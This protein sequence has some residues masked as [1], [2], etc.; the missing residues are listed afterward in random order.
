MG[1]LDKKV[2]VI[3]GSSRGIGKAIALEFAREGANIV[4]VAR[5]ETEGKLPGTIGKTAQEVEALGVQALAIKGDVTKEDDV[6]NVVSNTLD[7]FGRIDILV[8]NAAVGYYLPLMDTPAKH[9][10]LVMEINVKGPFLL[11]KAIV[12]WMTKQKSG[13]IINISSSAAND[14][15]SRLERP[16]G[17]RRLVGSLYGASKLA[18]ERISVG[19]A[20]ELK[21]AN[22]AV[23]ALKP[24]MPT[25]SEGVSFWNPDVPA[26]AFRSPSLYMTKAAVF[27][28][29][30]DATGISGQVFFDDELCQ[31]FN[32]ITG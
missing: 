28:A 15:F 13:S 9:W 32:I 29:M 8:N 18:L 6:N 26:S 10:D 5:S 19:L 2:A 25:Y 30:Q 14:I 3:T 23:N 1:K 31:K 11:I 16:G 21:G 20:E 12:P 24:S 27:L 17:E 22:I 4:V 7:R